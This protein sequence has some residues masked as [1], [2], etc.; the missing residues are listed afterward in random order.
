MSYQRDFSN[1]L[2]VGLV[3]VGTHAYRN[4]LPT[5]NFLPVELKAFC[6]VDL[7]RA[8]ITARQY[9]VSNCYQRI[10]EML[11]KECLDAVFIAAPPRLHP[12]LTIQALD[13]GL[14]VWLEKTQS[15]K[16]T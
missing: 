16:C 7:D 3:G 12:Q 15:A 1:K 14:H 4:I 13:A 11:T 2:S 8:R 9:G 5:M 6:D 10:E